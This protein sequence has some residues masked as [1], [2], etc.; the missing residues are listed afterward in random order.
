MKR[1]AWKPPSKTKP[2]AA[3]AAAANANKPGLGPPAEDGDAVIV[4]AHFADAA[5]EDTVG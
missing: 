5:E 1:A 2:A 3:A 4:D